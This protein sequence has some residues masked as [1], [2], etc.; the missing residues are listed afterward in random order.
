[1]SHFGYVSRFVVYVPLTYRYRRSC[2]TFPANGGKEMGTN[3]EVATVELTDA[4]IEAVAG[5]AKET[6]AS[7]GTKG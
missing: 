1:M 4:E 7:T 2:R 5:G 6:E 3:T